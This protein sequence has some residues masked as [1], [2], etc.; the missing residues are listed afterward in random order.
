M[1][2]VGEDGMGGEHALDTAMGD[3]PP[4]EVWQGG[5]SVPGD[6]LEQLAPD[7]GAFLLEGVRWVLDRRTGDDRR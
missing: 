6:T 7:F 2:V 5:A 4:V 1:V 3:D